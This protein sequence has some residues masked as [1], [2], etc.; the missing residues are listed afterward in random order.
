MLS[1]QIMK[2]RAGNFTASGNH[3][4]MAGWDI[5]E[6]PEPELIYLEDAFSKLDKKPLVG[7][8]KQAGIICTGAE[9]NE[10][11]A[12]VQY[13]K[14]N[15]G[16]VTYAKEKACETLFDY[17]PSL[18]FSTVHTRNGEERE[19]EAVEILI[20][21]TGLDFTNI[22]EDQ[23]HIYTDEVGAT[24]DGIVLDEMDMVLTGCEVKC[25]SPLE[26]SKLLL[27]NNNKDLLDNAP[28]FY[29]QIQTQMLVTGS[30]HWYFAVYN[31]YGKTE[32][33]RFKYIIIG[34]D[35]V[36]IKALEK[37]LEIA[38]QIKAEFITELQSQIKG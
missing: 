36:Y 34:R 14:P 6:P 20:E 11:W 24:P 30:N 38:K 4:L 25:K 22:G 18:N 2:D 10:M 16:L 1:E 19:L 21:K 35:D 31:P 23:A 33:I 13:Q 8:M 7:E 29:C 3:R 5:P 26:H 12:W 28:E 15:V 27:L 17:D 37:R 32:Q 9:I